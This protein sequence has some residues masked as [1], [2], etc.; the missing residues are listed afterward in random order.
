VI[1]E[2]WNIEMGGTECNAVQQI[3]LQL[4]LAFDAQSFSLRSGLGSVNEIPTAISYNLQ[5]PS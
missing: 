1:K 5:R 4:A 3:H 2:G